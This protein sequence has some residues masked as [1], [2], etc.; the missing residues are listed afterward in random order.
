[1]IIKCILKVPK[2]ETEQER[3]NLTQMKRGMEIAADAN[4]FEL[5]VVE[6][7]VWEK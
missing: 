2:L 7:R 1:M 3:D 5:R 6:E 4:G